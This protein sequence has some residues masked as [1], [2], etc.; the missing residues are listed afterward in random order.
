MTST[1]TSRVHRFQRS[2]KARAL[3]GV[4]AMC[5]AFTVGEIDRANATA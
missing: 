4:V 5:T 2:S 1:F 3:S